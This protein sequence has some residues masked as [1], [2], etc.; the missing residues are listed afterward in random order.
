MKF[1]KKNLVDL[2]IAIGLAVNLVVIIVI[3]IFYFS[4]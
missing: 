2:L 3:L 1:Q 4:R